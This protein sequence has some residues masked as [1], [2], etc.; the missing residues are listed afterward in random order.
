M[1]Y[2]DEF[3][4]TQISGSTQAKLID[5]DLRKIRR[6]LIQ[7]FNDQLFEDFTADP[8]VP[9]PK[10]SGKKDSKKLVIPFIN[11][12]TLGGGNTVIGLNY[13]QSQGAANPLL[14]GIV[15]PN[16][17]TIKEAAVYIE[18][19][20]TCNIELYKITGAS[21]F[22]KVPIAAWQLTT[23]GQQVSVNGAALNEV[24]DGA[25]S[26][27][28]SVDMVAGDVL[29]YVRVYGGYVKYNTPSHLNTL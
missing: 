10:I 24:T 11:F 23:S 9:L 3:N 13:I 20:G 19:S 15:L 8:L 17:V 25:A 29:S 6:S 14:A 4:A 12:I 5:D 21:P 16:G 22:T 2:A 27:Y 26:Y 28:I 18:A 1:G 7:R